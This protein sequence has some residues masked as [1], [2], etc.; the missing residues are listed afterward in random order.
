MTIVLLV[1]GVALVVVALIDQYATTVAMRG[2]GPVSSWLADRLWRAALRRWGS[3]RA[4]AWYGTA[5]VAVIIATWVVLLYG[6]WTLIFLSHPDAVVGATTGVPVGTWERLYYT[7]Y[8]VT[9]LGNGELRPAGLPWQVATVVA[10]LSGLGVITLAITFITPVLN[11][12]VHKRQVARTILGFGAS[13][14][15]I[16]ANGWDGTGF[17]PL[18][19]HLANLVPELTGLAQQHIAYPVL[20]YFHSADRTTAVAPAVAVLDDALTL[21]RHGVERQ[22]RLDDVTLRAASQ[23]VEAL[24]EA[25]H[26]AHIEPVDD[27]PGPP[28]LQVLQQ[29]EIPAVDDDEYARATADLGPRRALLMAFV[30]SDG[31][32]WGT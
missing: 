6:G 17:A 1:A 8:T 19:T 7:G 32:S 25:L 12:V 18:R 11:A 21:L 2:G 24:L 30:A 5:M 10:A 20:H 16:V 4:L 28:A 23:A 27:P 22:H 9:T 29:L 14:H 13:A 31:W 3:Q 26:A 15:D